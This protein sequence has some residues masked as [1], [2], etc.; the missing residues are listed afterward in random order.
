MLGGATVRIVQTTDT[1]LT[2]MLIDPATI[3]VV[4][5]IKDIE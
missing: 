3:K 5:E 2:V 1:R 4:G